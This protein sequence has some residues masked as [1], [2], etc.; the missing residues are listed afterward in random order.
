VVQ[1]WLC[2][3]RWRSRKTAGGVS[4]VSS[5]D[6]HGLTTRPYLKLPGLSDSAANFAQGAVGGFSDRAITFGADIK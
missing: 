5:G 6:G 2:I 3:Y 1:A 4:G